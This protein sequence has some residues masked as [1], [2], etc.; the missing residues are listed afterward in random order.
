MED[1]P[2]AIPY[3][4][5]RTKSPL[6]LVAYCVLIY[7]LLRIF[8][9]ISLTYGITYGL[10]FLV[11]FILAVIGYMGMKMRILLKMSLRNVSRRKVNTVIITLGLMIG[12]TIISGSLV[13][14]DTLDNMFTKDIYDSYDETDETIFTFDE[15][16]GLAF[17]NYT[18]Y[19]FLDAFITN[20]NP[21]S[22]KI[23]GLSPEIHYDVSALNLDSKL[24]EASVRIIGFD[25]SESTGFGKL[26]PLSGQAVTGDELAGH[27]VYVNE[28]LA[29]EI[30]VKDGH[31]LMIYY[32]ENQTATFTVK[33]VVET[34]GRAA[35]GAMFGSGGM[36][37]LMPLKRV[38]T[39]LNQTDK[40]NIIKVSNTG[41]KRSGMRHSDDVEEALQPYLYTRDPILLILKSKQDMV[42]NA[43]TGS[44]SLRNLFMVMGIFSIIAGMMLIVNIFVMLAEERKS[45]MGMARAVGMSQKQL[46]Y[47]FLFE[48]TVYS[49]LSSAVGTIAG[50]GVAFLIILAF[51]SIFG[52]FN[53]LQF[54]TFTT[55]SLILAFIGGML[56]TLL[57][58]L[59]ASR[60]VSKLNIIRAIRN[61]PEPRY[62]RHEMTE[63]D[64]SMSVSKRFGITLH[65]NILR[66]YEIVIMVI[67]A[68]LVFAAFVDIGIYYNKEWAGYG[69][70]AGFIYG[71]GLLLRRY[72]QDEKAFTFAGGLVLIIWCY[73]YDFYDQLFGI[74]MEGEMEMFVLS[75]LFMVSS[76][77]MVIMYNSN[78]ILSGLMKIF[79]RFKSIAPIFKTAISYPMDSRFRTGMTLAMFSLIIFT[80][81]VLAMIMGLIQGNI[82]QITDEN[83]GGYDMI[84]FNNPE[85]PID[86][87][88]L[89]I[90]ENDNLSI[91][92]YS[93]IVPLYTA[94]TSMYAIPQSSNVNK[95]TALI[96]E[97][98]EMNF[99][100]FQEN[101]TW[102][103]LIGCTKKFFKNSDYQLSEWDEDKYKDYEDA[104]KAIRENSS[105]A[106]ADESTMKTDRQEEGPPQEQD[107]G[108][109][110][111]DSLV[112]RD[113]FGNKKVVTIIGF[114][115]NRIV[116]GVYV[117]SDVV[118]TE[119][120][121]NKTS[122]YLTLFKFSKG[123]SESKQ[124]DLAKDLER[125]FLQ[126]GLRT[127]II[128]KEI[129]DMLKMISNF[130]Y[131]LEAFLGLGLIVGIAGLGI[132]TIRSVAERRQ[133]IG[134]LRA[135]GFKRSMIWKSFLIETSYIALLGIFIGV[136][137]GII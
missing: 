130:F 123:I 11:I 97:S 94:Y 57:T 89:R 22:A 107:F 67:C 23:E 48:G 96:N 29:E 9:A 114:T 122:S 105:L 71:M 91:G 54:F 90:E 79:G 32:G 62:S 65:D 30:D 2:T 47:M 102:Y 106:I 116:R 103:D 42:E 111:G 13:V 75:G 51:G 70:L 88:E 40:I 49:I 127:F 60:K 82:D 5:S 112:I 104:W 134:M 3:E 61:I 34:R 45:E 12:T 18:E 36:N 78:L 85:S 137:L 86:D 113:R 63:L 55:E 131:L 35:Y 68:F 72:V 59:L 64:P 124:E 6:R 101:G 66:H 15:K 21:I 43:E 4:P 17:F 33:Y 110:V 53:S 77:L 7:L 108:M 56:I 133:Q 28:M 16:G 92:D 31:T 27:E 93:K 8:V 58:I 26:Y 19:Q 125:E 76:A 135:I 117:H 39:L 81:T 20:N 73:P 119:E 136:A 99:S 132:I 44:K 25:F 46:M 118:T 87:I 50:M 10:L 52:G 109:E 14:G 126:Y 83:S 37:I 98:L 120:G 84:A 24:S 38:Q 100:S 128:K 69:G 41:D 1:I 74:D 129:E 115:K 121:F 95:M 80:V